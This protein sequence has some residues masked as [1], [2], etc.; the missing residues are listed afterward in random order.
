MVQ[1][2]FEYGDIFSLESGESIINL[3]ICYHH[4]NNYKKGIPVIWICHALTANSNPQEWWDT[5]VGPGKLIDSNK[6]YVICVNMLTSCYGSSGPSSLNDNGEPYLLSFPQ[7]TVR[8]I[9][10]SQNIIR[11]HIGIDSIDLL[12]GGSIGGFQAL[13]WSV[14]YGSVVKNLA[15]IACSA[16]IS[17]WATAFNESQRMALEADLSFLE[18]RDI[19]G[20][21]AG[22]RCARSIALIS[23]RSYSGYN[24]TQQDVDHGLLFANRACSYQQYQGKKLADRF[25]AYSY[26]YLTKCVDSHDVSRFRGSINE[27]LHKVQARCAVIGINSDFLFPVQDQRELASYINNSTLDVIESEFGHD[28]FLLEYEQLGVVLKNRFDNIFN[29]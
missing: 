11:E 22:L 2:L 15:L 26:Y 5:M 17:P 4:T 10:R 19:N 20:G 29:N 24:L 7:I 27:A 14:M 28:G 6:F 8:D 25:D 3:K 9:V 16:K 18:Q 23:Y 12:I 21:K 13:E 1:E